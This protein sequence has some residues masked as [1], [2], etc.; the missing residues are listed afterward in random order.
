MSSTVTRDDRALDNEST[1]AATQLTPPP[2]LRRRPA[3]VASAV[4]AICLGA[5]LAGWAWTATTNT[6]AVLVARH[7]IERG[8]V[9]QAS[10]LAQARLNADP[11]LKPLS[12]SEFDTAVGQRAALD[13][14]D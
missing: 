9:I 7:S 4:V 12:A 13:I 1:P 11:A 5:L 2:K 8:A 10:D 14:A 6:Q 3:L